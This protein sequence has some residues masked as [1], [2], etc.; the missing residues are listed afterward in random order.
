MIHLKSGFGWRLGWNPSAPDFC[1]LVAG[2]HWAI[3]L[4]AAEL[5]D[6]CR[7]ARQ[8]AATMSAMAIEL[9]DEETLTCEQE[10]ATIWLETEGFPSA[11]SLRFILLSGRGAEGG[12]PPKA[13]SEL[14]AALADA[15]FC[16]I[17]TDSTSTPSIAEHA[18]T[19]SS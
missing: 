18:P 7:C 16:E 9:M 3:E 4:T 5:S 13:A 6:F 1:G 2:Q 14:L 19:T 15:P 11:Y 17:G 12:W 10:T 8:L